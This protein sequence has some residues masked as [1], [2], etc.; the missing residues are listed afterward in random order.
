MPRR[1]VM[2]KRTIDIHNHLQPDDDGTR[3]VRL[4][5][6]ANVERCVILGTPWSA[7]ERVLAAVRKFGD[8][9]IGGV[10]VDPREKKK[11]VDCIR[12]YHAEGFR[13]VKLFPN[14]G[15]YPDDEAVRPFF[16]RVA[17]LGMAVLSHC[18]YLTTKETEVASY[19]S[20]PGRFEKLVRTFRDTIFILAHMG[21]NAGF[22]EAVLLA[23]RMPNMYVDCSPGQGLWVLQRAGAL[24]RGIPPGKLVWGADC[25]ELAKLLRIYRA[26]LVKHTYGPHLGKIFHDNAQGILEKIG[27][28]R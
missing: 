1:F 21:G 4:M 5:D 12:R 24:G 23:D 20:H 6:E 28:I 19:Y 8:R 11:A 13:I 15:Y 25:Y 22:L 17:E 2:P 18:G 16:E 10:Y 9:L 3:L 14:L 26:T 7:N 27:A